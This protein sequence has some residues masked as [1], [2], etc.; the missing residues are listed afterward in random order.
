MSLDHLHDNELAT[1]TA[2]IA[3]AGW[4]MGRTIAEALSRCGA[5][6]ISA[7]ITH[8]GSPEALDDL[9]APIDVLVHGAAAPGRDVPLE[10]LSEEEMTEILEASLRSAARL[11]AKVL[12]GMK[13]RGFG[14]I[15]FLGSLAGSRGAHGQAAHAAASAG[16][17]GLMRSTALEGASAGVTANLLEL[18][19]IDTEWVRRALDSREIERIVART[20]VGRLGRPEEVAAAVLFLASPR[21]S[22]IT[23]AVLPVGGGLG[24][25]L[26]P[27][28]LG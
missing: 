27:E 11:T 19:L 15:V 20:P 21:A 2:L 18:G 12:P 24:L 4:G 1:R 9:D 8:S 25:G 6:V 10:Q 26:F 3:E 17:E 22:Y 23:G 28:Q 13:E 14:R 16:L 7:D 5:R